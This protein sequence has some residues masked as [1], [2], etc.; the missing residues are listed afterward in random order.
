MLASI[1]Y[2]CRTKSW[3][4]EIFRRN[5]PAL[6]TNPRKVYSF[7]NSIYILALQRYLDVQKWSAGFIQFFLSFNSYYIWN[8]TLINLKFLIT[9]MCNFHALCDRRTFCR[10]S[11]FVNCIEH[12]TTIN[13]LRIISSSITF[14]WVHSAFPSFFQMDDQSLM[15]LRVSQTTVSILLNFSAL[16]AILITR[17]SLNSCILSYVVFLLFWNISS[18]IITTIHNVPSYYEKHSIFS[19]LMKW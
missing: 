2:A 16:F 11:R 15:I 5:F 8:W 7:R 6:S 19:K 4:V 10:I 18:Q 17:G 3:T 12:F 14:D 13:I 1:A 9:K